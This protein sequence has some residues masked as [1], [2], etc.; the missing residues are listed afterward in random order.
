MTT[1]K[2]L[3]ILDELDNFAA[4]IRNDRS[5]F[6]GRDIERKIN[7]RTTAIR[8]IVG[9][10]HVF[11]VDSECG[12][13]PDIEFKSSYGQSIPIVIEGDEGYMADIVF[14]A[15][16]HEFLDSLEGKRL[17]ITIEVERE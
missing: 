4:D 11:R 17:K 7:L 12:I 14:D 3:K 2:I 6:D 8:N 9:I 15:D 13:C 1:E 10:K 16:Y 5:G